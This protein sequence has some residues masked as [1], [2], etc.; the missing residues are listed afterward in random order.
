[1]TFFCKTTLYAESTEGTC[2]DTN[3]CTLNSIDCGSNG[4]CSNT[5][6]GYECTCDSGYANLNGVSTAVCTDVDE[7]LS[8]PCNTG[9]GMECTNSEGSYTC[10]CPA[11]HDSDGNGGCTLS[12]TLLFSVPAPV[13]LVHYVLRQSYDYTSTV[14]SRRRRAT[15]AG[16]AESLFQYGCWCGNLDVSVNPLYGSPIDEIDTQCRSLKKCSSCAQG[17][18]CDPQSD[19]QIDYDSVNDSYSC[20]SNAAG[21]CEESICECQ[22]SFATSVAALINANNGEL[23]SANMDIVDDGQ[24]CVR[25]TG[26]S[27]LGWP[28]SCSN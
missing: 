27:G 11:G 10:E 8:A 3:E 22:L 13:D 23:D 5:S 19:F 9:V 6:G 17:G 26:V 24:T 15:D 25:S 16:V 1:M 18:V 12:N 2:E 21:S 4:S 14:T 7:C 28:S 20:A